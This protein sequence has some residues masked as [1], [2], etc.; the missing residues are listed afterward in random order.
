MVR[1]SMVA[2]LAVAV[3]LGLTLGCAGMKKPSNEEQISTVINNLKAALE[4]KDKAKV[5]ST[6]SEKFNQPDIGDKAAVADLIQMGIDMGYVDDGKV[7][8]SQMKIKVDGNTATAGPI[9]ASSSPG[10]VTVMIDLAKEADGWKI[11]S[12]GEY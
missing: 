1:F 8:L 3:A 5:L 10:S 7:D 2:A 9:E 4:A 6:L 11:I 12:G